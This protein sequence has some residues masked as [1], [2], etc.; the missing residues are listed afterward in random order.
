[1]ANKTR[2]DPKPGETGRSK[3]TARIPDTVQD[4][5]SVRTPL[6]ENISK[7]KNIPGHQEQAPAQELA[8]VQFIM[9]NKNKNLD[10]QNYKFD[11]Y[12]YHNQSQII[13]S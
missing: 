4:R 12:E 6:I 7:G 10:R 1:M 2:T 3:I 11:N 5:Q 13:I 8:P 9:K